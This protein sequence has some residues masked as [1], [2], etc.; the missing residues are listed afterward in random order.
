MPLDLMDS[1]GE[2]CPTPKSDLPP[3]NPS[4]D[5]AVAVALEQQVDVLAPRVR[6]H[7]DALH[8]LEAQF[9][10]SPAHS[11]AEASLGLGIGLLFCPPSGASV[12]RQRHSVQQ[13]AAQR[14]CRPALAEAH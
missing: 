3:P 9:P 7:G 14:F 10:A 2:W 11:G 1:D 13:R 5:A 6:D 4:C 12:S 8:D